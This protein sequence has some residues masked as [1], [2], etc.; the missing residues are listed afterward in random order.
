MP[1]HRNERVINPYSNT[2]CFG[3]MPEI[4]NPAYKF[5]SGEIS[6][7]YGEHFGVNRGF[8]LRHIRKEHSKEIESLGYD[9]EE[10]VAKYVADILKEGA[11]IYCEF[12]RY[13]NE[14]VTIVKNS[15]GFVLLEH[16]TNNKNKDYYSV[17]TAFKGK[18]LHGQEIG[19]M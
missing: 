16:R 10:G 14:R 8:G 19:K 18:R 13:N 7:S 5:P 11:R 3:I 12:A 15:L 1:Q 17:I 4:N 9:G 2:T 6:L